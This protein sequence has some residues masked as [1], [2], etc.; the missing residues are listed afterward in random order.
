MIYVLLLIVGESL[1]AL[2]VLNDNLKLLIRY[3]DVLIELDILN[4]NLGIQ[5]EIIKISDF[6]NNGIFKFLAYLF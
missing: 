6:D 1:S 3:G 4:D 2:K 5:C